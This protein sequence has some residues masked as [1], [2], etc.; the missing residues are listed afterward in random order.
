MS[1]KIPS[2]LQNFFCLC[3]KLTGIPWFL[4][5]TY[6]RNKVTIIN[7][8]NPTPEVFG[9]HMA[10]FSRL[11]S[12]VT[13][14]QVTTALEKRD[15]TALPPKPLL[16]TIDDGYIGNAQLF[17]IIEHYHVPAV[18]Y[19]VAGV[20]ESKRGF[21]FD[22]LPHGSS[23]MKQLKAMPDHERRTAIEHKY[24]HTDVS[25]YGSASALSAEQLKEFISIGGTV[26]SHTIFH[27]LLS[28]CDDTIGRKECVESRRILEETL[29]VP[30]KH[31]ALPDGNGDIRVNEW[32]RNAGYLT[33]RTI[34]PGFLAAVDEPLSLPCFGM[35]DNAG[36]NKA[37]LQAT[38]IWY[39][40]KI[41]LG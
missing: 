6:A 36:I 17:N 15:F 7:Y 14:D 22:R 41:I 33:C 27:P 3:I 40:L 39:M 16:V 2:S 21:W 35:A 32:I 31:F 38:G 30:V 5:E 37:V 29:D 26:G 28:N 34:N 12:F 4:R 23:E 1:K 11:Y 20:V 10:T 18:I 19:V 13:I 25:E 8:H 9:R 24:S